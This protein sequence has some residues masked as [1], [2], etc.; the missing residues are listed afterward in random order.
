VTC[1]IALVSLHA[2]EECAFAEHELQVRRRERERER[3]KERERKREREREKERERESR[4]RADG[5]GPMNRMRNWRK[6]LLITKR[7]GKMY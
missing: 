7:K 2:P 5:R 4:E 6:C 3:E 1:I